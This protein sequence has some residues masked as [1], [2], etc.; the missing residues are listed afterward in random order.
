MTDE[1]DD[2]SVEVSN[3]IIE[4]AADL[5]TLHDVLC[6]L[7]ESD[8]EI[9]A[10]KR[11]LG[12]EAEEQRVTLAFSPEPPPIPEF[13]PQINHLERAH[14]AIARYTA[15]VDSYPDDDPTPLRVRERTLR[16]AHLDLARLEAQ[17]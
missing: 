5:D 9:A 16:L 2:D 13:K 3:P 14:A 6:R 10:V 8:D 17:Q 11:V 4:R 15:W 1:P 12:V 7:C